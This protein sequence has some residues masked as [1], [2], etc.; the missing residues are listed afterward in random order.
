MCKLFDKKVTS[1]L[2]FKVLQVNSKYLK[3]SKYSKYFRHSKY[4]KQCFYQV[5]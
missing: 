4:S 5:T 3:Y 1:E 2:K